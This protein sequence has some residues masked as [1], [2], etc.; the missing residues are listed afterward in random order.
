MGGVRANWHVDELDVATD[1]PFADDVEHVGVPIRIDGRRVS[2]DERLL[3]LIRAEGRLFDAG[4]TC[5]IR[6]RDDTCCNACP[7]HHADARVAPLC[8]VGREIERACTELTARSLGSG[9]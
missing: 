5:A 9:R 1:D 6:D 4:V 8:D 2:L 7:V 3:E